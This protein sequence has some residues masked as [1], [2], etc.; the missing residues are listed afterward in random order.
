[1]RPP[2]LIRPHSGIALIVVMWLLVLLSITVGVFAVL[3]RTETLQSRFLFDTTAARYA[4]EAGL[5]RAVFE[6]RNPDPDTRWVADGRAY[7]MEFGDAVVEIRTTDVAGRID[8]NR[9]PA[10]TLVAL[11]VSRGLSEEEAWRLTD[12]IEDWRDL[13]EE[14]RLFGAEINEYQ[15]AEYPYSPANQPFQ[16]V[17]ELQQ[18]IGMSYSLFQSIEDLVTVH[19]RGGPVNAAFASAEVLATLPEMD[20]DSATQFVSEREQFHPSDQVALS[21]PN[22]QLVNL[23]GSSAV[24]SIRSRAVLDNGIWTELDA[25]VRMGAD[26][27]GRPFRI[28]RWRETIED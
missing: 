24:F 6:M 12:A 28:L 2:T 11:F 26:T 5:H 10:E 25:T 15:A 8:L 13:D 16:S 9:A 3:A 22:G 4:A 14:P 18:V 23:Q 27:R 7:F 17:D 21:L 19:G 1:M 20:L